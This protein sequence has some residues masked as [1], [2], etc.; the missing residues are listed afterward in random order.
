M[1][2]DGPLQLLLIEDNPGDARYITALLEEATELSAR[3]GTREADGGQAMAAGETSPT[4]HHETR[5]A[6]GL[7]RLAGTDVDVV[8]LDLDL[9]DSEGLET[10]SSV[11]ERGDA[12]VVVLTGLRDRERGIRALRRGADE[13]L[14]KDEVNSDVLIRSVYHAIER[15]TQQRE[16]KRY[17]VLI[18]ESTDV[19]AVI[20]P[21]G[22]IQY[23]TPSVESV[24]GYA[25]GELIG[26]DGLGYVHP[27]DREGATAALDRVVETDESPTVEFRF[28]HRDGSWVVLEVRGRDLRGESDIDGIVLYTRDVTARKRREEQLATQR[29]ELA[30]LNQLNA[31]VQEITHTVIESTTREELETAVCQSLARSD[32]YSFAWIGE[33]DPASE[34]V[35]VRTEAGVEGYLDCV[36]ISVD[37]GPRGRGPTG[38]AVRTGTIQVA[39]NIP[40]NPDYEPWRDHAE[41]HGVGSSA[42]IPFSHDGTLYGVL[43]VYTERRH[44]FG[45]DERAVIGQLGEVVGHA[46]MAIERKQALTSEEVIEVE[47]VV[48]DYLEAVNPKVEPEGSISFDRVVPLGDGRFAVYGLAS[49]GA[50]ETLRA[51]RD[52]DPSWEELTVLSERD[53]EHRFELDIADSPLLD[54]I[55][56][57]DGRVHRAGIEES[58]LTVVIHLPPGASVRTVMESMRSAYAGTE[59]IAQRRTK[60]SDRAVADLQRGFDRELTARQRSAVEAAYFA[61][62]FEW[63][64]DS[65]GEE[66]AET[67]GVS[68]PTFHQHLRAAERKLLAAMFE[69]DESPETS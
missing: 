58:A 68:A 51:V 12:P 30:A 56:E 19:N 53:G 61:G 16:L 20:D 46:V 42:A 52:R 69:D 27:D 62:F 32:S 6:D 60:R 28:E 21:D 35:L 18:E 29:E 36:D 50:I 1:D 31:I 45:D 11:L 48:Q 13:Y 43:N 9:P 55:A 54:A 40:E 33:V 10:L 3:L 24:L 17:E 26:T 57:N 14:V 5:L 7:E 23:V 22:T 63:P 15:H 64:R 66:V 8:L 41:A 25:P 37:E 47:V 49:G 39:R 67:L 59:M 65:S 4:I 38:R 34:E 2:E 44:A